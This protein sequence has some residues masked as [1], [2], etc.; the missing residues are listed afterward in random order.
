MTEAVQ[1]IVQEVAD[2]GTAAQTTENTADNAPEKAAGGNEA[3]TATAAAETTEKA[4]TDSD[5]P[6]W[7][8]DWREQLAG[9]DEAFLKQLKRYSSP[10]TFAKGFKEREDLIRSG[11]LKSARPDGSDEKAMSEWRKENGVPADPTGYTIPDTVQKFMTDGDKPIVAAWFED[12]HSAGFNQEQAQKGLEWYAKT[13]GALEEQR[14]AADNAAHDKCEDFLRKEWSHSEYKANTQ[15]ATRYLANTPLGAKWADLRTEDGQRL[16][17]NPDFLMW[18]A[19]QGRQSFGDVAFASGESER[20][21]AD[22]KAEIEKLRD[23][24]FA[25]YDTPAIRK[26]YQEILAAELKRDNATRR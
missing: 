26:E 2:T 18:A 13:I 15:L 1:E 4:S 25:A 6:T 19:D 5:K 12:A 8:E 16:G 14:A 24:D 20:R 21:F 9:S 10:S 17:D 3:E 11:K 7:P 23:T 22:R